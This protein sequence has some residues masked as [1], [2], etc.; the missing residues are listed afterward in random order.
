MMGDG[1]TYLRPKHTLGSN[2][3][4]VP[5]QLFLFTEGL[6]IIRASPEH[7]DLV[8]TR[9]DRIGEHTAQELLQKIDPIISQDNEMMPLMI[10]P[11]LITYPRIL[12]GLGL[13]PNPDK[14]TMTVL[15]EAGSARR[16]TLKEEP[17]A[18]DEGWTSAK[19]EQGPDV[20]LYLKNLKS[21]YWF[22]YVADAKLVFFQY[23]VV[24]EGEE[25]LRLFFE[26]LFRFVN[27]HDVERF[28]IDLRWNTGGTRLLNQQLVHRLIR[29][30]KINKTGKL[31]VVVGRHTFSAGM[32]LA[33]EIERNTDAIF[34]GEPT[35]SSPNFVGQ[36]VSIR[37]PYSGMQGSLS[38]LYWQNS[39]AT[40]F[41]VWIAP[42]LYT[43]PSFALYSSNRDAALE[44]I[45][46]YKPAQ[47]SAQ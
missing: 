41:R 4:A 24:R 37:L 25:P 46:G 43:P 34:V 32:M 31:F 39:S 33:S 22:E 26:R 20:P 36:D 45:L 21:N 35:A 14:I 2:V 23:N 7:R 13:I 10:G 9:V 42:L 44:A 28:V 18:S 38:D 5:I 15:N 40:D 12:F 3:R 27:E 8:G 11:E 30:D 19:A 6:F 47:G 29:N 16:V 17:R 1:H